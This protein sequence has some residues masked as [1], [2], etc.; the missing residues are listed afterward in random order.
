MRAE[1]GKRENRQRDRSISNILDISENQEEEF[2]AGS[3]AENN[4]KGGMARC[5]IHIESQILL[6][7]GLG[8]REK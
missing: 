3:Q 7:P 6:P 5:R 1:E 2:K 8:L 4:R